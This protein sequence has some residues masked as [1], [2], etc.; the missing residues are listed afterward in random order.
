[1]CGKDKQKNERALN[2]SGPRLQR[3][4]VPESRTME[5]KPQLF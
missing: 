1:M 4:A 5:S 3:G 2:E